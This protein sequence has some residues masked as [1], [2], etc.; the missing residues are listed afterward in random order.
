MPTDLIASAYIHLALTHEGSKVPSAAANT[1]KLIITKG[2]VALDDA[3]AR[4]QQPKPARTV[5]KTGVSPW[6]HNGTEP[7][8]VDTPHRPNTRRGCG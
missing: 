4:K 8:W 6:R 2:T 1:I 7:V 3:N 5:V